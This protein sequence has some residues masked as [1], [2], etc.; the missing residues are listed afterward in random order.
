MTVN[1]NAYCSRYYRFEDMFQC[2]ET[3]EQFRCPNL[4]LQPQSWEAY[5]QLASKILDPITDNFGPAQLTF[6]FCGQQL[7]TIIL[8]NTHPRITPLLDQ[9]AAYE[10]NSKGL[11]VCPRLGAAVDLRIDGTSSQNLAAW[12]AGNL[13]F[14]RLYFYGPDRPIHVSMGPQNRGQITGLTTVNGRRI[15]RQLTLDA[16][17]EFSLEMEQS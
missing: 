7:R 8:K 11:P 2:G 12:V 5:S 15:P 10:L 3:W 13:P 16:L 17:S 4:P 14:D 6:G 9:H 1:L